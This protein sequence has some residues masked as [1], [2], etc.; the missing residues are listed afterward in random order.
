MN[1]GMHLLLFLLTVKAYSQSTLTSGFVIRQSR[2]NDYMVVAT[3]ADATNKKPKPKLS[4]LI[5][6]LC[7]LYPDHAWCRP[8]DSPNT[9][10]SPTTTYHLETIINVN[11]TTPNKNEVIEVNTNSTSV[12]FGNE[13]TNG[14]LSSTETS[15]TT[16][17]I[18]NWP[19]RDNESF[20]SITINSASETTLND[21]DEL[22][23]LPVTDY[24]DD[25]VNTSTTPEPTTNYEPDSTAST[26][27]KVLYNA[28]LIETPASIPTH[29]P[30]T[31]TEFATTNEVVDNVTLIETTTSVS[32]NY[33]NSAT[34]T[35]KFVTITEVLNNVTLIGT[36]TVVPTRHTH[37]PIT[38]TEFATTNEVVDNATRIE[39]TTSVS[40]NYTNSAT[41]TTA[42][43]TTN[44]VVDNATL[45][46]TTTS[47]STND[48][49]SAITSTEF[50][51]TTEVLNNV[52]LIGTM[53][54]VPTCD[55]N[56][57]RLIYFI[58]RKIIKYF[59]N[60]SKLNEILF[61]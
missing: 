1:N 29:Y 22:T 30:I 4:R 59:C 44:E 45:I 38:S 32:T 48:T 2:N 39:T 36:T 27:T 24:T 13:T 11:N 46:E 35:T 43:A 12:E 7:K 6:R 47:V 8:N 53:T 23:I 19:A 55:I 33:T 61:Y 26:T 57:C 51:T 50:E 17:I 37:Y 21:Y 58:I 54:A 56:I 5:R 3:T 40:T 49:N 31:S 9:T 52:T 16:T 28:T 42:F 20:E 14:N 10:T 60:C 25:A 34:N 41:N 15:P 18:N